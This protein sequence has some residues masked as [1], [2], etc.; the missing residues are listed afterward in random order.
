[1]IL[2]VKQ[3]K[4]SY[5]L[6]GKD[7]LEVLKNSSFSVNKGETTA[8]TGQ[9]GSGKTT[10]L[11]L[12][13]GLDKPDS[14]SVILDQQDL[15]RLG[16][17][18]LARYRAQKIG[19][20]FQQFHLMPHLSAEENVSL[21]LEILKADHIKTRTREILEKVG[22][23]D[24]KNHLPGQLSGRESQR[25]AI[26]R[27]LVVKPSLLLADEPTGNLDVETGEKV[28]DLLF[29][30]VETSGMTLIVVTHNPDLADKCGRSL[31]LVKGS[32]V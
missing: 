16:E 26:A 7:F 15:N 24:R 23:I 11:S 13:A 21:P 20:I 12:I 27:A 3:I 28:A 31:Q 19:M 30:L 10:L 32:L 25:V 22:L 8:I 9:S 2:D 14:G 18:A 5:P 4:K 1:M 29:S 6:P 17:D